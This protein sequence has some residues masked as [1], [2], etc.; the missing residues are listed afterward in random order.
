MGGWQPGSYRNEKGSS[1]EGDENTK[2]DTDTVLGLTSWAEAIYYLRS[3]IGS[4]GLWS[5]VTSKG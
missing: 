5:A 1:K 3:S 4:N 2:R